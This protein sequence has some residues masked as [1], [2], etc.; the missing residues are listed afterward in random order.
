[1]VITD[2][3]KVGDKYPTWY[4]GEADGLSTI[5]GISLY[6]GPYK[7]WFTH[8]LRLTAPSTN[9]GWVE[10]TVKLIPQPKMNDPWTEYLGDGVYAQ[11]DGY[12]VSLIVND[13]RNE[14]VVVL[15]PSVLKALNDFYNRAV[16]QYV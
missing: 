13:H 12:S 7:D 16:N 9:R 2:T 1:M 15:E 3:L 6:T 4:S 14:P 8:V 5:L 11:F 10:Q